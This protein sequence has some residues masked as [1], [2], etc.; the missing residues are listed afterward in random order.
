MHEERRIRRS[1][2]RRKKKDLGRNPSGEGEGSEGRVFGGREKKFC[3]GRN[4]KVRLDF[5]L[6]LFKQ[7]ASRWIEDLLRSVEH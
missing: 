4:E 6:N 3:Q 2:Q 1:Y 7:N 5:A